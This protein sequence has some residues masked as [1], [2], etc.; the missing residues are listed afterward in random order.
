M[1]KNIDQ[2]RTILSDLDDLVAKNVEIQEGAEQMSHT[3]NEQS[4]LLSSMS[5]K[6]ALN[7]EEMKRYLLNLN[8]TT[9]EINSKHNQVERDILNLNDKFDEQILDINNMKLKLVDET[10]KLIRLEDKLQH[11]EETTKDH[12]HSKIESR[13]KTLEVDEGRWSQA[14]KKLQARIDGAQQNIERVISLQDIFKVSIER[15]VSHLNDTIG[16]NRRT[17][18]ATIV[19]KEHEIKK[20]IVELETQVSQLD[21]TQLVEIFSNRTMTLRRD[22]IEKM[23]ELK[24]KVKGIEKAH[25]RK[26]SEVEENAKDLIQKIQNSVMDVKHQFSSLSERVNQVSLR[27]RDAENAT[28]TVREE[29][30]VKNRLIKAKLNAFDDELFNGL[31][32]IRDE[33]EKLSAELSLQ[34]GL[35]V[36]LR[37]N[38]VKVT[39]QA[40]KDMLNRKQTSHSRQTVDDISRFTIDVEKKLQSHKLNVSKQ[41]ENLLDQIN[42][43]RQDLA[44]ETS[45]VQERLNSHESNLRKSI[46]EVRD[47]F[48]HEITRKLKTEHDL[49]EKTTSDL[50]EK[51][52][53]LQLDIV[54]VTESVEKSSRSAFQNIRRATDEELKKIDSRLTKLSGEVDED[55]AN[56]IAALN[57]QIS[58]K[59]SK[60][61]MSQ[62]AKMMSLT[63]RTTSA[64]AQKIPELEAKINHMKLV[65]TTEAN[66]LSDNVLENLEHLSVRVGGFELNVTNFGKQLTDMTE[67]IQRVKDASEHNEQI[68]RQQ[69]QLI[70]DNIEKASKKLTLSVAKQSKA[71]E[72]IQDAQIKIDAD[73]DELDARIEATELGITSFEDDTK[74]IKRNMSFVANQLAV[75]FTNIDIR[76]AN[77]T[78]KDAENYAECKDDFGRLNKKVIANTNSLEN[79]RRDIRS[80]SGKI[81]KLSNSD[82][83]LNDEIFKLQLSQDQSLVTLRKELKDGLDSV[84][85]DLDR[86]MEFSK[87]AAVPTTFDEA[88]LLSR[89]SSVYSTKKDLNEEIRELR[90]R[91]TGVMVSTKSSIDDSYTLLNSKIKNADVLIS[92]LTEQFRNTSG[93][94]LVIQTKIDANS[95][96]IARIILEHST[97]NDR[98]QNHFDHMNSTIVNAKKN[99]ETA[100]ARF[101]TDIAT[102]LGTVSK[103]TGTNQEKIKLNRNKIE[104]IN[105]SVKNI[106]RAMNVQLQKINSLQKGTVSEKAV[107]RPK[108]PRLKGDL[109]R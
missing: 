85:T 56:R 19:A 64:I 13:L 91:M 30:K 15:T 100:A 3:L 46:S 23:L 4:Q 73:F 59:S 78:K 49:M 88:A 82:E 55:V 54:K 5:Q 86:N 24:D 32:D 35:L 18:E 61:E 36:Y 109:V 45:N 63:E 41:N 72:V 90:S 107:T 1:K 52:M 80:F 34:D 12:I 68:Q 92:N 83:E 33:T 26:H 98:E 37:E 96:K 108:N 71:V 40:W 16:R 51:F 10:G 103:E 28:Q 17:C 42:L 53:T 89:I 27:N 38:A 102:I 60:A 14:A 69:F 104:K 7:E 2:T 20:Q 105:D 43:V 75:G 81:D 77:L 25:S 93:Q 58:T 101:K 94:T 8:F 87:P 11:F 21:H 9:S 57:D 44:D 22:L 84:Q 6:V 29:F 48:E 50:E 47:S 79:F 39:D 31:R 62:I 76:I 97:L 95:N 74:W 70:T 66:E 67:T 99:F 65:K 106:Q